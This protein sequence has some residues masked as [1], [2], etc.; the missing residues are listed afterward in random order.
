VGDKIKN[1]LFLIL[2][3]ARSVA[4]YDADAMSKMIKTTLAEQAYQELRSRIVSGRLPGGTRLLPNDLAID[5]GISPTPVKEACLLLEADGLVVSSSRRGMT[6]RQFTESDV[7]E[8]YNARMMLEQS[9]LERAFANNRITPDLLA[10]LKES[11]EQHQRYAASET[12]DDLTLAL[13]HD[14]KFHRHLVAAA[15]VRMISEWH[16]RT[17][18]QTHTVFV[19]IPGNYERS[20][21]EH[22]DIFD[23]LAANSLSQSVMALQ[24]HLGRSRDNT[25]LQVKKLS[26]TQAMA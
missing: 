20:V 19:S 21:D 14:R 2:Y 17:V 15:G 6:V 10:N 24:R 4:S 9:A 7:E 5:L 13:S 1:F 22:R 26:K 16:A 12:L 3:L 8:L 25:L 11:L 18:S 23:A